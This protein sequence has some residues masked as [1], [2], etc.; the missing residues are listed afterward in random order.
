MCGGK[1]SRIEKDLKVKIE[2]PMLRIKYKPLIEY[3]ICTL[4]KVEKISKIYAAVSKNTPKTKK[5]LL[6]KF[7]G[8]IEILETSGNEYSFDY[9]QIL[10]FFKKKYKLKNKIKILFVPADIPLLS[11]STIKQ[12]L[13][14]EQKKPCVNIVVEKKILDSIKIDPPYEIEFENKTCYHTGISI[15]DFSKME[16][17]FDFK[18]VR[19]EHKIINNIDLIYNVNTLKNFLIVKEIFKNL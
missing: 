17:N 16:W 18:Y 12:I 7:F 3:E 6:D 1:G 4:I 9:L 13:E 2:K 14:M 10:K 15:I 19:E 11:L 5:F 8:I